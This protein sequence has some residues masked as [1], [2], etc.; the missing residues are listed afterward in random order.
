[1]VVEWVGKTT[2]NSKTPPSHSI[3]IV[4]DQIAENS[5][6][7]CSIEN[8]GVAVPSQVICRLCFLTC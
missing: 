2:P 4:F 7:F 8:A 6:D 1:M 5:F 3:T